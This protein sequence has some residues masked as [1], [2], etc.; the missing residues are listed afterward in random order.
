M[1]YRI[2]LYLLL[3]SLGAN[4]QTTSGIVTLTLP[5]IALVD[6]EPASA[7]TFILDAPEE[8]G[9]PISLSSRSLTWLNYTSAVLENGPSRRINAAISLPITGFDL[10]I[11]AAP[12]S[13]QGGG[14]LG[15]PT[16]LVTLASTPKSIIT[17]IRGAYTGNGINNGHQLNISL[18]PKDYSEIRSIN[19]LTVLITFTIID[20]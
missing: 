6:L 12:A 11:E 7:R 3:L 14:V 19:N 17:G 20:E 18:I 13:G 2:I 4:A 5:I 8:A 9:N 16:G 10:K 15:I 1:K